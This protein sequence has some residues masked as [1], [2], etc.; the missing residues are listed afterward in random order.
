CATI[1]PPKYKE[2]YIVT[3]VDKYCAIKEAAVPLVDR[4]NAYKA[5]FKKE[6]N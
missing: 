5:R 2:G 1:T 3:M 4:F 6:W